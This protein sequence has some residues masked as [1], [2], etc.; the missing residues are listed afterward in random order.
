MAT[1]NSKPFYRVRFFT[2]CS[3]SL[4]VM[5]LF[6]W[7]APFMLNKLFIFG[8]LTCR[9]FQ[10]KFYI[11]STSSTI[12]DREHTRFRKFIQVQQNK[13]VLAEVALRFWNRFDNFWMWSIFPLFTDNPNFWALEQAW[14]FN[15]GSLDSI[16]LSFT[17]F[18]IAGKAS[19]Y[20]VL[21]RRH[22]NSAPFLYG[23]NFV[24]LRHLS[25]Y[26]LPSTARNFTTEPN[27]G[28]SSSTSAP[29]PSNASRWRNVSVLM[30]LAST[31][32]TLFAS[33][34]PIWANLKDLTP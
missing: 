15:C 25:E 34:L 21:S 7:F 26:G 23:V 32:A 16:L 14:Q 17:S 4:R 29:T 12:L 3:C 18:S 19:L 10:P 8:F 13:F 31:D 22:A 11:G 9:S 1:R 33:W 5:T 6:L 27:Y 28:K 24:G 30:S 2:E 20:S